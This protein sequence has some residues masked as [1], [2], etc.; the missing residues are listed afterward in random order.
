MTPLTIIQQQLQG[1]PFSAYLFGSRA[2]GKAHNKSDWDIAII[3]PARLDAI[4]LMQIEE[5][6]ESANF[7]N[8]V[9]IVDLFTAPPGLREE[10]LKTIDRSKNTII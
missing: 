7:P 10:I 5:S 6:L 8:E 1:T 3:G 9:D 4:L 2:T